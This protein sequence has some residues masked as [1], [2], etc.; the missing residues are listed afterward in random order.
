MSPFGAFV[1]ALE[2]ATLDK[3]YVDSESGVHLK[4][5][6]DSGVLALDCAQTWGRPAQLCLK[7]L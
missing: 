3:E 5:A 6:A 1:G 7:N 4:R 2:L